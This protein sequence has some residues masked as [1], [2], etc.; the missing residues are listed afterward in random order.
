[1]Q[2][3]PSKSVQAFF[4]RGAFNQTSSSYPADKSVF[5]G[6]DRVKILVGAT[7]S[8][9]CVELVV[10]LPVKASGWRVG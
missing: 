7:T 6:V 8:L 5:F 4:S 10:T 3:G 1:M 2:A 9:F